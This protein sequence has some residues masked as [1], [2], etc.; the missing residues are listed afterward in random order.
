VTEAVLVLE[1]NC[2]LLSGFRVRD[3]ELHADHELL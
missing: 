2:L 1:L 3:V